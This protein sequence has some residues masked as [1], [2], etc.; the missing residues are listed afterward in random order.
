MGQS[1]RKVNTATRLQAAPAG[2][3]NCVVSVT[4]VA[5]HFGEAANARGNSLSAPTHWHSVSRV[6]KA[7]YMSREAGV[8]KRLPPRQAAYAT[9]PPLLLMTDD[10]GRAAARHGCL[11]FDTRP[12]HRLSFRRAH[13]RAK[14]DPAGGIVILHSFLHSSAQLLHKH[15]NASTAPSLPATVIFSPGLKRQILATRSISTH[16]T[17]QV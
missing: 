11:A 15:S 9:L 1:G 4:A 10:A 5:G 17:V 14:R 12:V 7:E 2:E 6:R 3:S 16:T 13:G 8:C